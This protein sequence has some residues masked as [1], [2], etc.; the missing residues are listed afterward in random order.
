MF[1]FLSR[2]A[3]PTAITEPTPSDDK[4]DD[5]DLIV[6][7]LENWFVNQSQSSVM[8]TGNVKKRWDSLQE[9]VDRAH[10]EYG[11]LTIE[12]SSDGVITGILHY[13]L[14]V[15]GITRNTLQRSFSFPER[16]VSF[17]HLVGETGGSGTTDN[18]M[19]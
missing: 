5:F 4:L 3:T 19:S 1:C 9:H 7:R 11:D 15:I 17:G 16:A 14:N 8:F 10:E 13:T 2:Q 12:K 18:R 6:K